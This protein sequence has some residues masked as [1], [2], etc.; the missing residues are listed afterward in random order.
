MVAAIGASAFYPCLNI[1]VIK[2]WF[3]GVKHFPQIDDLHG[4]V[5]RGA[6]AHVLTREL[7]HLS[8]RKVIFAT[9]SND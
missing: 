6:P 7:C 3:R 8:L 4:F 1:D 9:Q 2:F 5:N